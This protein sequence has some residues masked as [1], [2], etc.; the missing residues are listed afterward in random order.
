MGT[1][2][3]LTTVTSLAPYWSTVIA[4]L[5]IC[6]SHLPSHPDIPRSS[7][8]RQNRARQDAHQDSEGP[9]QAPNTCWNLHWHL[10]P[11]VGRLHT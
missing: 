1:R 2:N 10:M 8:L 4:L 9:L 7:H 11:T 3:S 5:P 6:D